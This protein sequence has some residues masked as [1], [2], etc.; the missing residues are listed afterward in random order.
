MP[1]GTSPLGHEN[2]VVDILRPFFPKDNN[3]MPKRYLEAFE[4]SNI[5]NCSP[6]TLN[7]IVP[8]VRLHNVDRETFCEIL[9]LCKVS[10]KKY[11]KAMDM[12]DWFDDPFTAKT[13]SAYSMFHRGVMSCAGCQIVPRGV[14]LN[15][16]FKEPY[17]RKNLHSLPILI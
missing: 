4:P 17:V 1:G 8:F 7:I 15:P 14:P 5:R 9:S 13:Y 3:R 10:W 16:M 11:V 6:K 12:Y 2:W